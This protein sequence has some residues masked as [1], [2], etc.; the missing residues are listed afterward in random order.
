MKLIVNGEAYVVKINYT[1]EHTLVRLVDPD[2]DPELTGRITSGVV[3][4]GDNFCKAVDRKA[5]FAIA[6]QRTWPKSM[7]KKTWPATKKVRR[8]AWLQ[9]F[10]KFPIPMQWK[11]REITRLRA[12][13]K[14]VNRVMNDLLAER[15]ALK[16]GRLE[17]VT[18]FPVPVD[19]AVAFGAANEPDAD[20]SV[21]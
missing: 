1:D 6:V 14:R 10:E 17:I 8:E 2:V 9:Y 7:D 11:D 15:D 16:G 12:A 5:A 20:E 3:E 19:S 4:R 21:L 13:L 18:P